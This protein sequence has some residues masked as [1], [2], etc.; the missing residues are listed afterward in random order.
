MSCADLPRTTSN[1]GSDPKSKS[2]SDSSSD[3]ESKTSVI[4][5]FDLYILI[6]IIGSGAFGIVNLVKDRITGKEYVIKM[7]KKGG[8][9]ENL[10]TRNEI[11]IGKELNSSNHFCKVLG[12]HEDG[13]N[14]YILME[15]LD[16]MDLFDF[17]QKNPG[18]FMNNPKIFWFVIGEILQGLVYLHSQGIAHLDIK[19]ENVFLLLDTTDN[20]IGVKLMDL[21]LAVE[22]SHE[23]KKFFKGTAPYMAPEIFTS[24][25][26]TESKADIWSLGITAYAMLMQCLPISSRIKDPQHAQ[27]EIYAK[28]KKLLSHSKITPFK[29]LSEDKKI[30]E[31]QQFINLFFI[32][33]PVE[34]PTA[35]QLLDF[36]LSTDSSKAQID[37]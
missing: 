22:I 1:G 17:I 6:K 37:H 11:R 34:R 21:G 8:V 14:F 26:T 2:K 36:I 35:K 18:F 27:E 9:K 3:F 31:I 10:D 33:N 19:L 23:D 5:F 25:F 32:I 13:S 29:Q 20:I 4:G 30:S 24:K 16:G 28:I 12:S 15:Y 7:V